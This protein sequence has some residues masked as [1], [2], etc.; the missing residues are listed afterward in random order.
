MTDSDVAKVVKP[1][2][3][4]VSGVGVSYIFWLISRQRWGFLHNPPE[5]GVVQS[6][7]SQGNTLSQG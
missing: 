1:V 6:G 3:G 4:L 7:F 5:R 2:T